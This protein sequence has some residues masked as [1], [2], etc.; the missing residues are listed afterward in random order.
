MSS[1]LISGHVARLD[2]GVPA[3][4]ALHL[5][6]DTYEGRKP[7]G[8][9]RA[10]LTTSG[11]TRFFSYC[12]VPLQQFYTMVHSDYVTMMMMVTMCAHNFVNFCLQTTSTIVVSVAMSITVMISAVQSRTPDVTQMRCRTVAIYHR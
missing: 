10:A 1:K 2:A 8:D 4:D 6:V 5:M 12:T 7:A 9:H 3:H 11:S